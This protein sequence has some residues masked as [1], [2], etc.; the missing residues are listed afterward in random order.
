[1]TKCHMI[2]PCKALHR[3]D[4]SEGSDISWLVDIM[5]TLESSVM[6]TAGGKGHDNRWVTAA[7]QSYW[8]NLWHLII[9]LYLNIR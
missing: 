5:N 4:I 8:S 9:I 6:Y 3:V 2:I 1:M 7:V